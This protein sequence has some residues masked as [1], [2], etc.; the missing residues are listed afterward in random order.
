MEFNKSLYGERIKTLIDE[1]CAG[2][3]NDM[4]T[5]IHP[6]FSRSIVPVNDFKKIHAITQLEWLTWRSYVDYKR[7][8]SVIFLRFCLYMFIGLLLATP[9]IDVTKNIDQNGIQ[10]MQG[11][12]YL[13]VTETVFTFNYGVFYTFPK[14]L[15]LLLRDMA[16]GL[17][18]PAPY[19]ISKIAVLVRS[20]MKII[21]YK[22][23]YLRLI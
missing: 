1:S 23:F 3:S 9:Y 4:H 5:T 13:V 21:Q 6:F 10:N 17:Y 15:P 14:E 2:T 8:Y 11:L 20:Q 12:M 18:N 7:N 16:S 22:L 19:Y